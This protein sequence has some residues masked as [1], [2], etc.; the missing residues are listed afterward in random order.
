MAAAAKGG[1]ADELARRP[2]RDG[3]RQIPRETTRATPD[4]ARLLAGR[5][6]GSRR[7]TALVALTALA[8]ILA[9]LAGTTAAP[10]LLALAVCRGGITGLG[11]SGVA[12]EVLAARL[13]VVPSAAASALVA[14]VAFGAGGLCRRTATVAGTAAR[15]LD[16]TIRDLIGDARGR[17]LLL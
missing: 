10:A 12:G 5:S 6:L 1:R 2:G 9:R 11:T 17:G 13:T 7:L 15:D 3:G 8:A 4:A 16:L 14:T